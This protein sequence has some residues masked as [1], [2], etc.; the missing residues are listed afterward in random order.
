RAGPGVLERPPPQAIGAGERAALMAEEL[1][2][3]QLLRQRRAVDRDQRRFRAVTA[4]MQF[5]RDQFLARPALAHD[6]DTARN[7]RNP[8]DGVPERPHRS[9]VADERRVAIE[10]RAERAQLGHQLPARDGVL[11][12][13]H[14]ALDRLRL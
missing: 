14:D 4:A 2:L 5:A 1:A 3:D 6:Q 11:D 9:A 8:R 7:R 10:A 13:L 12:L